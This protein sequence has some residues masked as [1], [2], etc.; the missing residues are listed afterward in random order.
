[1]ALNPPVPGLRRLVNPSHDVAKVS[2]AIPAGETVEVSEYV[3]GQLERQGFK[4]APDVPAERMAV[5][6]ESLAVGPDAATK[7]V[8]AIKAKGTKV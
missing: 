5:N 1:M 7:V 3:A 2:V 4:A 6:V 8:E